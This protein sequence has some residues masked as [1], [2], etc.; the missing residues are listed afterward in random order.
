MTG[1]VRYALDTEDMKVGKALL[2]RAPEL[3]RSIWER[4][5]QLKSL[6][7]YLDR[8]DNYPEPLVELIADYANLY[9]L[10]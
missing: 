8:E 1:I 5:R 10:Q 3:W 6:R 9:H 7:T 4:R 2:V